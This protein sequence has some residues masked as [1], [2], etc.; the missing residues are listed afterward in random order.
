MYYRDRDL[1]LYA[2]LDDSG[3]IFVCECIKGPQDML[4]KI[5]N[6]PKETGKC[7]G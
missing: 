2:I 3:P 1:N 6:F 7:E 4:G 5:F